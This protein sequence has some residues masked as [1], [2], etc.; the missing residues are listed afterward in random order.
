MAKD[1]VAGCSKRHSGADCEN[2][3]DSSK[4]ENVGEFSITLL[5]YIF[6]SSSLYP[7]VEPSSLGL[8]LILLLL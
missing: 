6:L 5:I 1:K 8:L 2:C 3:E 7:R 4:V